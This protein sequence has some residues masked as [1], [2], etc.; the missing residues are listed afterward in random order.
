M[1]P[2]QYHF[3]FHSNHQDFPM[4]TQFDVAVIGA[5]PAGSVASALLRKKGYSGLNLNQDKAA[6]RRQY[7]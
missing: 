6:S 4:S 2:V 5:G 7:K 1:L 3:L